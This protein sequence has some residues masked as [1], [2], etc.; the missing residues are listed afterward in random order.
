MQI[1]HFARVECNMPGTITSINNNTGKTLFTMHCIVLIA[2]HGIEL[3][4]C[5]IALHCV[6]LIT[7]HCI[8]LGHGWNLLCVSR[9]QPMAPRFYYSVA[10]TC[11]EEC[12]YLRGWRGAKVRLPCSK[13][14]NFIASVFLTFQ[15]SKG[16]IF[17]MPHRVLTVFSLYKLAF[18]N[19]IA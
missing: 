9:N 8:A 17:E 14:E 13:D 19:M 3:I 18:L 11:L 6:A 5:I 10:C 1:M 4:Y 16:T 15:L 12:V 2:L 7:L